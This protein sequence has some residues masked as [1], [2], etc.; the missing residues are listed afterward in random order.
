[1]NDKRREIALLFD[2]YSALLS[3]R[4]RDVLDLYYNDDLSLSEIAEDLGITRQG[5][6]N[7]VVTGEKTLFRLEDSLGVSRRELAVRAAAEKIM[8]LSDNESVRSEAQKLLNY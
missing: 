7:A 1:M 2:I 6:R 4:Q 3:P 8:A 5:V